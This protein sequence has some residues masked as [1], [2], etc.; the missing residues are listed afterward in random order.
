M[1]VARAGWWPRAGQKLSPAVAGTSLLAGAAHLPRAGKPLVDPPAPGS[2]WVACLLRPLPLTD[3]AFLCL[4]TPV[5]VKTA[6]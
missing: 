6:T 2:S 5:V 3:H 4:I 1:A